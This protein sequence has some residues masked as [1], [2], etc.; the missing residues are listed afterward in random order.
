MKR[1]LLALTALLLAVPAGA[2]WQ[3][4][5]SAGAG[6][7]S[8]RIRPGDVCWW[9]TTSNETTALLD[10]SL[11]TPITFI[12]IEEVVGETSEVTWQVCEPTDG[13][14]DDCYTI[15]AALSSDTLAE[16]IVHPGTPVVSGP[17]PFVRAVTTTIGAA[18]IA[19]GISCGG[20]TF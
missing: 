10:A 11:C 2:T 12:T 15:T 18:G 9:V 16:I 3:K 17:L 7:C 20:T 8:S 6:S 4:G 19:V 1:I 13:A 14:D 5:V